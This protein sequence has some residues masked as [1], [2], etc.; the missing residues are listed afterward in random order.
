MTISAIARL[1]VKVGGTESVHKFYVTPELCDEVIIGEDWLY[2]HKA[3][4]RFHLTVL[5]VD[6]IETPLK[7]APDE[8]SAVV[9]DADIKF[10]PR[11]VVSYRSRLAIGR[12]GMKGIIQL[13]PM[14]VCCPGEYEVVLC[15]AV[16]EMAE[17]VP[18]MLASQ[19]IK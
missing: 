19:A 7:E 9:A 18:I 6:S 14:E 2:Q 15:E 3:H 11:T 8:S 10:S 13:T 5:V 16:V 4:I 17:V 12:R 1:P